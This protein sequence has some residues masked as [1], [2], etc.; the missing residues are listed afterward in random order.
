MAQFIKDHIVDSLNWRVHQGE[1]HD[2][3]S[4]LY[5]ISPVVRHL[6]NRQPKWPHGVEAGFP[7]RIPL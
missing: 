7:P 6:A 3:A 5:A 4:S 2:D 1:I